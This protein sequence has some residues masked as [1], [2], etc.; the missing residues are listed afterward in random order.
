MPSINSVK[1]YRKDFFYHVYNRGVER[2][3]IYVSRRDYEVFVSALSRRLSYTPGTVLDNRNRD[4]KVELHAYCLMPNHFH[5]LIKQ[6]DERSLIPFMRSLTN[7]YV[8]YFNRRYRRV[9]SLF[10]DRYKA[11]IIESDKELLDVSGYIHRN[12]FKKTGG[13]QYYR[14]SSYRFYRGNQSQSWLKTGRILALAGGRSNYCGFVEVAPARGRD[15][16][17]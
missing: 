16:G 12:P 13:Y 9:G 2:R 17:P 3:P 4:F 5:L 8:S 15:P 10:Q 1:T 11:R 6:T 7:S 14:H